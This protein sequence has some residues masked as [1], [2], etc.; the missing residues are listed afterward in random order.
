M[1]GRYA[2]RRKQRRKREI[3]ET[4]P[5]PRGNFS[6]AVPGRFGFF[7]LIPMQPCFTAQMY[8]PSVPEDSLCGFVQ[9]LHIFLRTGVK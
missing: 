1:S 7:I 4:G 9:D 5:E 8:F 3:Q 6:R 2:G